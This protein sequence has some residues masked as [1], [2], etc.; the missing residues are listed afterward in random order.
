[1]GGT[2]LFKPSLT[3]IHESYFMM[4]IWKEAGLPDG[5]INFIPDAGPL[6][7]SIALPHK[8]LAGVNFVGSTGT[9]NTLWKGVAENLDTYRAYPR[10][11]GET[12]GKNYHF[13][14]ESADIENVV[15]NTVRGAFD[16]QGQKC[17]AT[18]RMYVPTNLWEGGLKDMLCHETS[19]LKMGCCTDFSNFMC[20]V[21]D[22][23]SF[24]KIS[25]FIERVKAAD[26]AEIIIGGGCDD[27]VGYFVE[28]TIVVT[29]NPQYETM[30]N[31]IFGPVLTVCTY[32]PDKYA[33]TLAECDATSLYGLTGSIFARDRAAVRQAD[34][35]L[36]H[37]AGN[38]YVNDKCT[39]AAVGEQPFG[40][41]RRSGTN[42]KSGTI[43]NNLKW[44]SARTVK[45]TFAPL[46][47]PLWP[48]NSPD[49]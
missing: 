46:G 37:S 6:A 48:C 15:M 45:E 11:A 21:I 30:C 3:A 27:S 28:P 17:S 23:T 39:G 32:D 1:M 5:V 22:Q 44:V 47:S 26:D 16:Y 43:Y 31:E 10:V 13:V 29:K 20:A 8:D 36:V 33:E 38:F 12:G 18:S 41:A 19:K 2:V 49:N 24:D 40:G 9:F 7:S 14:H 4:K 35:A 34:A 25:G 42:D